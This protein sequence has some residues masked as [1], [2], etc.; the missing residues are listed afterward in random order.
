MTTAAKLLEESEPLSLPIVDL[1]ATL[2]HALT[3]MRKR[4]RSGVLA[5]DGDRFLLFRAPAIVIALSKG[6]ATILRELPGRE[7]VHVARQKRD[8]IFGMLKSAPSMSG[9]AII[10]ADLRR[11]IE[12]G[13]TDC[14][15]E[16][17]DERVPNGRTGG[18]CGTPG[19]R[20]GTV[21]CI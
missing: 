19:H 7:V 12:P 2:R 5:A 15:C 4:K 14:Y 3:L 6:T 10:P 11:Q 1:D 9:I 16:I 17:D 8:G 13:P 21:H 18:D 20:P